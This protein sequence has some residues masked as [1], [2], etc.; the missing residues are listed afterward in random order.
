MDLHK[1]S[2]QIQQ[3]VETHNDRLPSIHQF[4]IMV[5][6]AHHIA[7]QQRYAEMDSGVPLLVFTH[8][9]GQKRFKMENRLAPLLQAVL[10]L[11]GIQCNL[12]I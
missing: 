3:L 5:S 9:P 4:Q 2:G 12:Q 8:H 7:L 11:C 1:S 10:E 6:S